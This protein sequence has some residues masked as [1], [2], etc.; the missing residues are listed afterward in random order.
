MGGGTAFPRPSWQP[1]LLD[2]GTATPRT[3][4]FARRSSLPVE[5]AASRRDARRNMRDA[6]EREYDIRGPVDWGQDPQAERGGTTRCLVDANEAGYVAG[7][8]RRGERE[9]G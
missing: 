9:R 1:P 4:R 3:P 7:S 8:L 6:R 5:Q 2:L